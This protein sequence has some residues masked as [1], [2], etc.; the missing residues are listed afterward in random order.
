MPDHF[1]QVIHIGL[2]D[3]FVICFVQDQIVPDTAADKCF[4][5]VRV[6]PH[7]PVQVKHRLVI[8]VQIPANR[9]E[10]TRRSLAFEADSFMDPFHLVHVG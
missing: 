1:A 9:R 7:F 10:N 2:I 8:G 5:H 6:F 4:F 3:L